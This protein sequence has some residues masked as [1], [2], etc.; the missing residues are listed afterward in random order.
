[1]I[2]K[3]YLRVKFCH[4]RLTRFAALVLA[5]AGASA[6]IKALGTFLTPPLLRFP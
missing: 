2:L 5:L 6:R 4:E 1:M 3:H